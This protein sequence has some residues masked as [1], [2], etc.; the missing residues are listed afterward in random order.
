[1]LINIR[2]VHIVVK[3]RILS[4]VCLVLMMIRIGL[5]LLHILKG[6]EVL[7]ILEL[8]CSYSHCISI[9]GSVKV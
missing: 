8:P 5:D 4:A 7:L 6:R 3:V 1:M 9:R 2:R